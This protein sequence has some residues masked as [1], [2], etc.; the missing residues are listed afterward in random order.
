MGIAGI[1]THGKRLRLQ[2]ADQNVTP[3][4]KVPKPA[5]TVNAVAMKAEKYSLVREIARIRRQCIANII[6]RYRGKNENTKRNKL[7]R[8]YHRRSN[9]A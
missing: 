4:R 8:T 1:G 2:E 9:F 5:V 7:G 3:F 6:H